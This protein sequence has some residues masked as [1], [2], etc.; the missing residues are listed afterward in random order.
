MRP[1]RVWPIE[2]DNGIIMTAR[3]ERRA[4]RG[5]SVQRPPAASAAC[6]SPPSAP[7][8]VPGS[9][10]AVGTVS[11]LQTVGVSHQLFD[12]VTRGSRLKIDWCFANWMLF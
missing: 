12:L 6:A 7:A 3:D 11:A 8:F 2:L 4:K 10:C 1:Q 9:R 5:S